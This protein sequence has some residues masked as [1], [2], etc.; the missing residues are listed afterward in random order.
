MELITEGISLLTV[1][2]VSEGTLATV[3]HASSKVYC[4]TCAICLEEILLEEMAHV[5][6][7]EH[8]YCVTCILR[9]A[10]YNAVPCCPQCKMPFSSLGVHRSLDGCVHDYL[11]EESVC[12][13]LRAHWFMP[14]AIE[15]PHEVV[16]QEDVGPYEYDDDEDDDHDDYEEAYFGRSSTLRIGNR[17]WGDSGYVRG[18]RKE[19]RPIQDVGAGSSRGPRKKEGPKGKAGRRARRA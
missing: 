19:A 15:S 6:G 1:D 9:W 13:L 18:G 16:E 7:C 12:L 8:A 14:L 17:R 5:K 10:S 2:E 11:V 4:G 3:S